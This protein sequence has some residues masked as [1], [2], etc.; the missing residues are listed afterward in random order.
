MNDG[1]REFLVYRVKRI[2]QLTHKQNVVVS[3]AVF[4][5]GVFPV[6]VHTIEVETPDQLHRLRYEKISFSRILRKPV[7]TGIVTSTVA[8]APS[9]DGNK[10]LYIVS[11]SLFHECLKFI[12]IAQGVETTTILCRYC[13]RKIDVREPIKSY[14]CRIN[15][16]AGEISDYLEIAGSA[17]GGYSRGRDR[18]LATS[19]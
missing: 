9:A 18:L 4:N 6:D 7:K 17:S 16:P 5:I 11:V 3:R 10:N 8:D 13:E 14:R 1:G 15:T 2:A 12:R 19:E